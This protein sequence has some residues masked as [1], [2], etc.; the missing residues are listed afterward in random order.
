MY[1]DNFVLSFYP[2]RNEIKCKY[3]YTRHVVLEYTSLGM[4]ETK[5]G[6]TYR[7]R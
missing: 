2:Q 7:Y 1:T 4:T 5:V 3:L 6:Q